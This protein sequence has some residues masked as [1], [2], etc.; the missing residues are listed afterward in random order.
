MALVNRSES[1][2][3][4]YSVILNGTAALYSEKYDRNIVHLYT[5]KGDLDG[6]SVEVRIPFNVLC[7]KNES[8]SKSP[9][10]QC[11]C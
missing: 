1:A 3:N 10:M 2:T 5:G 6:F 9:C 7:G 11:V 8:E 4:K